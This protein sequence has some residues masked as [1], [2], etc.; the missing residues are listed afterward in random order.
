[1]SR[2]NTKTTKKPRAGDIPKTCA[3]CLREFPTKAQKP[4]GV[5]EALELWEKLAVIDLAIQGL[6]RSA[7]AGSCAGLDQVRALQY[8]SGGAIGD[9]AEFLS[10]LDERG[11]YF[12]DYRRDGLGHHKDEVPS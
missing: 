2:D 9:M 7:I 6:E 11:H 1:M 3:G 12:Q 10:R 5:D 4:M 8:F